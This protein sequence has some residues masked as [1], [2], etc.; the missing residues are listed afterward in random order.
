[1]VGRISGVVLP[2]VVWECQEEPAE[3]TVVGYMLLGAG[4]HVPE[5]TEEFALRRFSDDSS[6]GCQEAGH[7][8][9][10]ACC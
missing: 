9:L 5:D 7:H 4:D 2:H 1:M 10:F 3:V 6:D 8:G